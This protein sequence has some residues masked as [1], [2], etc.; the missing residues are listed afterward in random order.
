MSQDLYV[1]IGDFTVAELFTKDDKS[2]LARA[3]SDA[4]KD[5]LTKTK[6]TVPKKTAKTK[7]F[8]LGGALSV[9]KSGSGATGK[10][11]MQ[12]NRLPEDKLYG[13]ATGEAVTDDLNLIEEL[14]AAVVTKVIA[15]QIT[16]ALKKAAAET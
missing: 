8:T 2:E 3:M 1:E 13:M 11:A 16:V 5:A 12:L 4:A 14:A 6:L 10:V 15:K 9:K 7:N